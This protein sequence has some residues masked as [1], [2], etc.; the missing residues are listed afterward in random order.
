ML[1][2]EAIVIHCER[3]QIPPSDLLSC[4]FATRAQ[5]YHESFYP[6]MSWVLQLAGLIAC[7]E[8]G[9]SLER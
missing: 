8:S 2:T 6:P 9:L 4:V 7:W 1:V 5:I 3:K